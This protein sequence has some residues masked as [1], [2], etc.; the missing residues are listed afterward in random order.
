MCRN[1]SM[2]TYINNAYNWFSKRFLEDP[3]PQSAIP[4]TMVHEHGRVY[5]VSLY[6][7]DSHGKKLESLPPDFLISEKTIDAIKKSVDEMFRNEEL[8]P[9]S[10]SSISA[11]GLHCIKLIDRIIH[12]S[13]YKSL[14][15][16]FKSSS[17][18][19][20]DLFA[21]IERLTA[22]LHS[23]LKH[24]E[25][26]IDTINPALQIIGTLQDAPDMTEAIRRL[27]AIQQLVGDRVVWE[28]ASFERFSTNADGFAL[29]DFR[30]P[31]FLAEQINMIN[32]DFYRVSVITING[33]KATSAKQVVYDTFSLLGDKE[34]TA[35]A[36]MAQHQGFAT[37][38]LIPIQM[39]VAPIIIGSNP[40]GN[41]HTI[42]CIF[43]EDQQK[44]VR[45]TDLSFKSPIDGHIIADFIMIT[46]L[47][48]KNKTIKFG[49]RFGEREEEIFFNSQG[50]A[51]D[52]G[53]WTTQFVAERLNFRGD[54]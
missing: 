50:E 27:I 23:P 9:S 4:I 7:I 33:K 3:I 48:I 24:E 2:T 18:S 47:D 42:D 46:V 15:T 44:I 14:P 8:T 45:K 41:P 52:I 37:T 26:S 1:K 31:Q 10:F 43:N 11:R 6:F 40:D 54:Q 12:I 19:P 21:R 28:E 25:V 49:W 53:A 35:Y 13:G 34:K 36:L 30:D 39:R 38:S 17:L 32:K 20:T 51:P 5:V 22:P 29:K 16:Q